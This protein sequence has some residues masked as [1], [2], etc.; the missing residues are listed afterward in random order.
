MIW[1]EGFKSELSKFFKGRLPQNLLKIYFVPYH[2]FPNF[3]DMWEII[4]VK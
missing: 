1:G 2:H 4:V 3:M